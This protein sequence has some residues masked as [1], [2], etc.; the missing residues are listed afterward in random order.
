LE[1]SGQRW[2][3][4]QTNSF[5]SHCINSDIAVEANNIDFEVYF[6]PVYAD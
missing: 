3:K 6:N 2:I 5:P 1:K 4:V